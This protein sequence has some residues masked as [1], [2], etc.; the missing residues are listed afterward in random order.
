MNRSIHILIVFLCV[1]SLAACSGDTRPPVTEPQATVTPVSTD[2]ASETTE[3]L[4]TTDAPTTT[5]AP[6]TTEAPVTTEDPAST[7]QPTVPASIIKSIDGFE[8]VIESDNSVTITKYVGNDVDVSIPEKIEGMPVAK[9]GNG[10]FGGVLTITGA[11]NVVSLGMPDYRQFVTVEG[12]SSVRSV[13]IPATVQVIETRAFAGC[14]K[15]EKIVIP[16][17]VI[18]I[19]NYAFAACASLS[20]VE[21]SDYLTHIGSG[22]FAFCKGLQYIDI[23]NSVEVIGYEA[24]RQSGLTE[25]SLPNSVKEVGAYAFSHC[26]HLESVTLSSGMKTIEAFTFEKCSDLKNVQIPYGIE[27]IEKYA[28]VYCTSY[29]DVSLPDSI[30]HIYTAAFSGCSPKSVKLSENLIYLAKYNFS[31]SS[32]CNFENGVYYLGTE[33]NPYFC[34]VSLRTYDT[35]LS[36]KIQ[37]GDLV[38]NEKAV[39]IAPYAVWKCDI[40][41]L[42]LPNGLRSIMSDAI[43]I[44]EEKMKI[45]IP[46]TVEYI[47]EK[48]ICGSAEIIFEKADTAYSEYRED[49][50]DSKH[51]HGPIK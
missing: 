36:Y 24:F 6:A 49:Y 4:I 42:T 18:R 1:I 7:T 47:C 34:I 16:N 29:E 51:Y 50:Y 8:Y 5:E 11:Q 12:A 44:S 13:I 32:Y 43:C 35:T 28:F 39:I 30:T 21:L 41:S 45:T 33:N 10:A 9:I 14:D 37:Y 23:P 27:V 48:S 15:L 31:S 20:E 22:A 3:E 17:S 38:I 40:D 19:E 26:F 2:A 46:N 25:I